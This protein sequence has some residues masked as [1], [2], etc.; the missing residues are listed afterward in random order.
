MF[1][2]AILN[3]LANCKVVAGFSVDHIDD[4]VPL[5]NALLAGGIDVIELTLRTEAGIDATRAISTEVPEILVGVGTILAP[6][7]AV[8]VKEAGA[9]FGVSPGLN[10]RVI[11][12]A[13]AVELPFAPG[14]A[15]PS[16]I[17]AAIELDCRFVKYFPAAALGGVAYLRSM[18]APY[19]HLGIQYFPLGGLNAANM[20]EY[21]AEPNVPAIGGSWIVQ[22]DLVKNKDWAAI[23]T[24]AQEV[25]L[26]ANGS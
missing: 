20:N 3:R 5:A 14:I 7:Q 18:S 21:L 8:Q 17:E 22:K 2:E 11:K 1:P 26:H 12:A 24:R 13:K 4:A 16:D 19:A 15:T 10:P 6:E 9:H 23:T 25:V